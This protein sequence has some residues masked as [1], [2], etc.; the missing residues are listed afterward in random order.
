MEK[1]AEEQVR[2]Y[3]L[4]LL[5]LASFHST[6]S[7]VFLSDTLLLVSLFPFLQLI[8]LQKTGVLVSFPGNM[9]MAKPE[10]KDLS[11][12]LFWAFPE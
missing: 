6:Q 11:G 9:K 5:F 12:F 7:S 1:A 8:L 3:L 2:H 4:P 10:P